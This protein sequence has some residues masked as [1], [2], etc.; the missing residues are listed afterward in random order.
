MLFLKEVDFAAI[1]LL[2]KLKKG[3][4]LKMLNE[5]IQ[6]TM[7]FSFLAGVILTLLLTADKKNINS[8]NLYLKKQN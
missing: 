8:R 1:L 6:L 3:I 7:V 2:A 4:L 5:V